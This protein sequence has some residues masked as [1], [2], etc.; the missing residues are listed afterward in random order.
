MKI[1]VSTVQ[2]R[3]KIIQT[4]KQ[5]S[6][7]SSLCPDAHTAAVVAGERVHASAIAPDLG[8][9]A[10]ILVGASKLPVPFHPSPSSELGRARAS[11]TER[12]RRRSS[13]RPFLAA[14]PRFFAP[15]P[16]APRPEPTPSLHERGRALPRPKSSSR[17]RPPLS[18]SIKLRP[19]LRPS[20]RRPPSGLLPRKIDPR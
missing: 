7:Y 11:R 2:T 6:S 1:G 19:E 17:T 20:R 15:Q 10:L 8:V 12:S 18:T 9:G 16:T 14:P 3:A 4:S 13:H 5:C